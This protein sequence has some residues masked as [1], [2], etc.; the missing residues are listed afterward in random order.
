MKTKQKEYDHINAKRYPVYASHIWEVMAVIKVLGPYM[1]HRRER[2]ITSK[3][4]EWAND[5][6]ER[7]ELLCSVMIHGQKDGVVYLRKHDR[8][9]VEKISN[10]VRFN[11]LL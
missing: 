1:D 2:G 9:L 10:Y 6:L 3:L 8:D 4:D 11:A 5:F 7:L